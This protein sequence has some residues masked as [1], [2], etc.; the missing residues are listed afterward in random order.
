MSII[1]ILLISIS[2]ALDAVVVSV[3][4][5]AL[6]HVTRKR[7]VLI[8][9]TF[10]VFQ[11][12]MPLIGYALGYGF[13]DMLAIYGH[14][15]GFVLI[16]G[17]G[18]KMLSEALKKE[19]IEAEKDIMHMRTLLLLAV[20]TSIDA[21]VIG[22]TFNFVSVSIPLT[23]LVIGAVTAVLSYI[24]V[25]VGKKSKHLIGTHIEVVGALV[26]MGLAVKTLFF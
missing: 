11:A 10:G 18:L 24:G 26:L 8:A 14:I 12:V 9:A 21:L 6:G 13:R 17:V 3:D 25:V 22:I 2:L 4:A 20:A 19:D 23:V 16:G 15:V 7:T 5:G 1:E